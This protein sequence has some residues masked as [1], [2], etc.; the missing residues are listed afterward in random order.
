LRRGDGRSVDDQTANPIFA[1]IGV[2]ALADGGSLI[3]WSQVDGNVYAR[4]YLPSGAPA[5]PQTKINLV[6]TSA[7]RPVGVAVRDDGSFG[8]HWTGVGSDG[9]RR[10]YVRTFASGSLAG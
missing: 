5:G 8:I 1:V 2:G 9:V 6:T 10:T 3:A 4:R 7:N